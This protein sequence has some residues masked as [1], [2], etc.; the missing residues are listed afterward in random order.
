MLTLVGIVLFQPASAAVTISAFDASRQAGSVVLTWMTGTE[1]NNLGFNLYRSTSPGL[2]KDTLI[3]GPGMIPSKS[4]GDVMGQSYSFTDTSVATNQT[5]Y[6]TL[7][8]IDTSSAAELFGPA[9]APPGAVPAAAT[10]TATKTSTRIPTPTKTA[11]PTATRTS[12]PPPTSIATNTPAPATTTR[13][14][15][16]QA[17]RATAQLSPTPVPKVAVAVPQASATPRP[18]SALVV[19]TI[20]SPGVPQAA[21]ASTQVGQTPQEMS[22]SVDNG[23]SDAA[24]DSAL[25]QRPDLRPLTSLIFF[26]LAGTLG[27]GAFFFGSL[28]ILLFARAQR[29]R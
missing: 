5:Y 21:S 18:P 10:P 6:Y 7:E 3:S 22:N 11:I 15:T 19:P 26:G 28:A 12:T 1:V 16:G 29:R 9:A 20:E 8:S 13:T 14:P 17:T 25:A 27:L 23:T 4:F 2:R 24:P